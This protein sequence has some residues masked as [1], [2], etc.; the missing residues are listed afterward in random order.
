MERLVPG[1][2]PLITPLAPNPAEAVAGGQFDPV[3]LVR[4]ELDLTR[5]KVEPS[6][7]RTN[8]TEQSNPDHPARG[9]DELRPSALSIARIPD[10]GWRPDADWSLFKNVS[11]MDA[12]GE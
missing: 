5:I 1:R 12:G 9:G 10:Q 7:G 11:G 6:T 3:E 8:I 2:E 4:D